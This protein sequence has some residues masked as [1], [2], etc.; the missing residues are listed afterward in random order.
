VIGV[1]PG[2]RPKA[3]FSPI[4]AGPGRFPAPRGGPAHATR[5]MYPPISRAMTSP[6]FSAAALQANA[7]DARPRLGT[8]AAGHQGTGAAAGAAALPRSAGGARLGFGMPSL[9][10]NVCPHFF[11]SGARG[12]I[13]IQA[14][15]LLKALVRQETNV[16]RCQVRG[17]VH[18]DQ[19]YVSDVC[20]SAR[21][22]QCVFYEDELSR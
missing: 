13:P 7:A 19:G 11:I 21:F 6:W 14:P 5:P 4:A 20:V 8:P 9:R 18:L 15:H 1:D 22:N 10:R 16:S 17:G 2:A 3:A 12:A